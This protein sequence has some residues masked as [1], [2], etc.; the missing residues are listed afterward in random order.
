MGNKKAYLHVARRRLQIEEEALI[1]RYDADDPKDDED[2]LMEI[3]M[4]Q[5][6]IQSLPVIRIEVVALQ[7]LTAGFVG[8]SP[9][10]WRRGGSGYTDRVPEIEWFEV[11]EAEKI[12]ASTEVLKS[13]I[14]VVSAG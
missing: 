6:A 13:E 1:R 14:K 10:F 5:I 12:I 3:A 9:L 4:L 11:E 2:L 7:N 8:N